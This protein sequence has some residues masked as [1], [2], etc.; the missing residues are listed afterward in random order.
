MKKIIC[1]ALNAA[2]ALT[3]CACANSDGTVSGTDTGDGTLFVEA[4]DPFAETP[5]ETESGSTEL[6]EDD[7]YNHIREMDPFFTEDYIDYMKQSNSGASYDKWQVNVDGESYG[8][9]GPVTYRGGE[10]EI[11][12]TAKMHTQ[13]RE[14]SNGYLVYVGCTPQ[15]I[16]LNSAENGVSCSD[17]YMAVDKGKSGE[18]REYSIRFTPRLTLEN[19]AEKDD[20]KLTLI[21]IDNPLFLTYGTVEHFDFEHRM[22]VLSQR[23]FELE[24]SCETTELVPGKS[25]EY[26]PETDSEVY[27]YLYKSLR[28]IRDKVYFQLCS[29]TKEKPVIKDGK[30]DVTLVLYGGGGKKTGSFKVYFYVNHERVKIDGCDYI[31]AELKEGLVAKYSTTVDN[32]KP[33]DFVYAIAIAENA[34]SLSREEWAM[35]TDTR[36]LWAA[37]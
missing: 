35:K 23:P 2:L 32:L 11:S 33:G 21:T 20:L 12:F 29:E 16:S 22:T 6:E 15:T 28:E 9:E 27:R 30:A 8:E 25:F 24:G 7:G 14:W 3:L 26:F 36:R 37:D 34:W 19:L 17:T 13:G 18:T 31:T 10:V 1:F 5:S 4:S